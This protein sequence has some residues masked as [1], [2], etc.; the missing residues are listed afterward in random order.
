[1]SNLTATLKA[2]LLNSNTPHGVRIAQIHEGVMGDI[3]EINA[4]LV[5]LQS[6]KFLVLYREDNNR[7]LTE[8]DRS[9]ALYVGGSPRHIAYVR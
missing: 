3:A 1:M 8:A 2:Y 4:T 5:Q 7:A 9:G 6:D